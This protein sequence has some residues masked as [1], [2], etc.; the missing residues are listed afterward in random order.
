MDQ[1]MGDTCKEC[2]MIHPPVPPGQCPMAK[3]EK[4]NETEH[5][6]TVN[7]FIS[8]LANHLHESPNWK[9]EIQNMKKCIINK[10]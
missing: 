4:Q 9:T 1:L 7:E 3:A 10:S 2:G 8:M 6:K 5:G